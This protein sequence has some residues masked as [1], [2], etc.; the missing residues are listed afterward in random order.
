MHDALNAVEPRYRSYVC[1]E[2]SPGADPLA[3]AAQAAYEV[4]RGQYPGE[5]R[6]L[7]EELAAWLAPIPEGAAKTRGVALGRACAAKILER[8]RDDGWDQSADYVFRPPAPG[9]YAEFPEHSGTPPG[10]V[11]GAGWA[12]VR[13]FALTAPDQLRVPPPPAVDGAEY[14]AAF[15]EVKQLGRFD[16]PSRTRDQTHLALWW[17]DFCESSMNRLARQ[18]AAA[19]ELDPWAASRLFALLNLSLHDAYVGVFE[20]KLFYDHWRPYTAI[21][22]AA[23]DGNPATEADPEWDN[24]H[25]HTYPFPSYP[26]AHGAACAATL[27]IFAKTFGDAYRFTLATPEVNAGGPMSALMRLEPPTRSFASFSEA[28]MECALSRVYLG[29]HFRYDSLA[30]NELGRR[31]GTHAWESFLQPR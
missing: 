18:L 31:I 30:G 29:I 15:A 1:E 17:K 24:T 11:F 23:A 3:A 14:A 28:A 12:K 2:R 19:E 16:S 26:S 4:A 8:R 9:V 13:P 6:Q 10:F 27:T 20:N 7:G 22:R 5:E 21:R 25:R